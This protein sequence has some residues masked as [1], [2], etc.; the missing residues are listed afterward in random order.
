MH[1]R[2]LGLTSC[3]WGT[4][5]IQGA[6]PASDAATDRIAVEAARDDAAL[7]DVN[8][9]MDHSAAL[10][11]SAAL[12]TPGSKDVVATTDRSATGD[13][14]DGGDVSDVTGPPSDAVPADVVGAPDD[15]GVLDAPDVPD[16][17]DVSDVSDVPDVPDVP[18]GPFAPPRH[19]WPLSS[20]R[21]T[22]HRPRLQWALAPG[23]TGAQV[24]I[25]ADR[26]CASVVAVFDA[27]G[28]SAQPPASLARGT[29]W[30]RL[31]SLVGATRGAVAS[32]VWSFQATARDAAVDTAWLVTPDFDNDGYGDA[33]LLRGGGFDVLYGGPASS[34]RVRRG[35]EFPSM[36]GLSPRV[37]SVGDVN[38]DGYGDLLVRH[39]AARAV[40]HL[41]G[42]GG[43]DPTPAYVLP[44][45]RLFPAGDDDF[46]GYADLLAVGG[47]FRMWEVRFY[48]GGA[49]GFGAEPVRRAPLDFHEAYPILDE[50]VSWPEYPWRGVG[51]VNGDRRTDH[52]FLIIHPLDQI[53]LAAGGG[54]VSRLALS[55]SSAG[56]NFAALGDLDGDGYSG[57]AVC[58]RGDDLG[59]GDVTLY[60]GSAV[61]LV[62]AG[63][64]AWR[65]DGPTCPFGLGDLN[66]DGRDDYHL[67]STVVFGGRPDLP[68]TTDLRGGAAGDL[69]GDG[70]DD[71]L[72]YSGATTVTVQP[73][74]ATGPG[75]VV[76]VVP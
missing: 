30:W 13:R 29:F 31:T 4:A 55:P 26:R 61:G 57:V 40:V 28:T 53:F 25:C 51:D 72:G 45:G 7:V 10:D 71:L 11:V 23:A 20:Y 64:G 69:N 24:E 52:T 49:S 63:G 54:N 33:V 38:G 9:S 3:L 75:A 37:S 74:S 76:T 22:S 43:L 41:G 70:Y 35:A 50:S 1:V 56:L 27:G 19:V 48:G 67:G 65:L 14:S 17:P 5:C 8:P 46:D 2:W 32:R 34:F 36:P 47:A 60:A 58:R 6:P 66:G 44:M 68:T 18:L 39:T 62:R 21:V 59:P 16:V 73:G 12:D 42:E 15:R